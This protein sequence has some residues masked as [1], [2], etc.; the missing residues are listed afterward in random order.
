MVS[1]GQPM[2]APLAYGDQS[3]SKGM[4]A[5]AHPALFE[6]IRPV[7]YAAIFAAAHPRV[8]LRGEML[9]LKGDCVR[10]VLL[11]TSGFVKI[12]QH[13]RDGSEVILGVRIPGD[14]LGADGL[15][16]TGKHDTTAQA[17]RSCKALVWDERNFKTLADRFPVLHQNIS[18]LLGQDLLELAE[19]FRELATERVSL[20]LARQL[21]RLQ[22]KIGRQV[23]AGI[24]IGLSREELAQMTGTTLFTVSRLLSGWEAYGFVKLSRE[25]VIICNSQL[26]LSVSGQS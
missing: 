19:R 20:R 10:Q 15:L 21:I 6:G 7:D 12:A 14:V 4:R 13:G 25:T 8:F 3:I 2:P 18:R 1:F 22:H 24:E 16:S 11:L 9:F 17:F 5:Q 26:L 23:D